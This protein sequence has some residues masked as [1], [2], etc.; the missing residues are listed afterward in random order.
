MCSPKI[1]RLVTP[2]RLQHRRHLRSI[3]KRKTQSQKD[4][5]ADYKA[6]VAKRVDEKKQ[7]VALAKERRSK[8]QHQAAIA[9][10]RA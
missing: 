5:I 4:Q 2:Q 7:Q 8:A 9:H 1:Q 3:Q 10:G 6:I